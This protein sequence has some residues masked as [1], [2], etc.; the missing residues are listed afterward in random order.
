MEEG[1]ELEF[2]YLSIYIMYV[3]TKYHSLFGSVCKP[4]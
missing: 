3:S 1:K 4:N 2:V